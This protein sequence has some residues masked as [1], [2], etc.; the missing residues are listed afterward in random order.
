MTDVK[1]ID[2]SSVGLFIAK[3]QSINVLPPNPIWQQLEPSEIGDIGGETTQTAR[4]IIRP[5]RQN[6]RGSITDLSASAN[7]TQEVSQ[8]NC[9]DLIQG[10]LFADAREI[11]KTSPINGGGTTVTCSED[12]YTLTDSDYDLTNVKAN[13]LIF[14]KD[15]KSVANNG[16]KVV[17]S[18]SAGVISCNGVVAETV[19]KG[20]LEVVGYRAT[21]ATFDTN[22]YVTLGFS[23]VDTLGLC[24]GQW[25]FIGSDD[26]KPA[27]NKCMYARV[28][29][30]ATDELTLDITTS[31]VVDETV[32]TLDVFF[33]T[34]IHNESDIELIKRTTYTIEENLGFTDQ[35]RTIPQAS[36]VSGCVPSELTINIEQG[37][38]ASM[39]YSYTGCRFYT[40]KGT[41]QSGE[42]LPTWD[43]KGYNNSNEVY[44]CFLSILPTEATDTTP[45]ALFGYMSNASIT[46]N[47]NLSENK[48]VACLGAF[49]ISAGKFDVTASP[50]VYFT[51]VD[52]IEA[53]RNNADCGLQVIVSRNNEGMIFDCPMMGMG[54]SIPSVSDGEP[55]TMSLEANGAKSKFGYTFAYNNFAYLP[56]VAMASEQG[57]GD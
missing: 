11:F 46:I 48:A 17:T 52:A 54:A 44:G 37:A 35:E 55:I 19:G 32:A 38:L 50:E 47:N 9:A 18:A 8:N 28:S 31:E 10:F 51:S 36:Y 34:V 1:K 57:L 30:I 49:D 29:D 7:F 13:S 21:N 16:L 2:S 41:L 40:R 3:E 15:F 5:D 20:K 23:G 12:T 22:G 26:N 33:G 56:Q 45:N 14:G 6:N 25:I 42:R 4:T 27:D 39:E 53:L 43:E 24:V